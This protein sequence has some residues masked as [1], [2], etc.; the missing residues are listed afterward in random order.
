MQ[1]KI[2]ELGYIVII[3][4]IIVQGN[5]TSAVHTIDVVSCS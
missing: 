4:I 2:N 1:G 5:N 3:S